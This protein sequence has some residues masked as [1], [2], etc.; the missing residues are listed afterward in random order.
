MDAN[1]SFEIIVGV[2]R[3]ND[4]SHAILAKY[5][6]DTNFHVFSLNSDQ[7]YIPLTRAA[8]NRSFLLK[9]AK[10]NYAMMLDGDD[11]YIDSPIEAEKFLNHNPNYS[12]Y[13]HE[14]LNFY[15]D[16]G[17]MNKDFYPYEDGQDVLFE[18][19]LKL[20]KYFHANCILFRTSLLRDIPDHLCN[21]SAFTIFLLSKGRI[22]YSR[23]PVMAYSIGI[24]SIYSGSSSTIKLLSSFAMLDE[25]HNL[26]PATRRYIYKKMYKVIENF[27]CQL[28]TPPPIEYKFQIYERDLFWTNL[29]YRSL[30]KYKSFQRV[31]VFALYASLRIKHVSSKLK[32]KF[33]GKL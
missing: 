1:D 8:F 4:E 9:K 26:I 29:A 7:R 12:G 3:P 20:N 23:T 33:L 10:G 25:I 30:T 6:S 13:A 28:I 32:F 24:D 18:R 5:S 16:S 27:R 2:D 14:Y 31:A 21:D 17:L 22:K 15:A 19:H 11:F